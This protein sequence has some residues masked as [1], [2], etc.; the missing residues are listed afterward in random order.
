MG[1]FNREKVSISF[2]NQ[3]TT[4][5]AFYKGLFPD[6]ELYKD[7]TEFNCS[8]MEDVLACAWIEI[9]WE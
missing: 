8:I 5:D 7:L 9:R 1:Q 3:E 6:G 4:V 2:C